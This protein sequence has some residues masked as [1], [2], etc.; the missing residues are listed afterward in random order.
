MKTVFIYFVLMAALFPA[1]A[2]AVTREEAY[3]LARAGDSAAIETAFAQHQ[4][5]FNTGEI[6]P[7]TYQ[8]PYFVFRTTEP[9]VETAIEDWLAAFPNSPQAAAA[10]AERLGHIGG[11]IRGVGYAREVPAAAMI[12]FK[13]IA[14]EALTLATSALDTEPRHL[15]AA[16]SLV[17][18][19]AYLGSRKD[20]D[21]GFRV[22]EELDTPADVL[23]EGLQYNYARWGGGSEDTQLFCE[24]R[25]PLVPDISVAECLAKA[26]YDHVDQ[27]PTLFLP[28][29]A[30]L[31]QGNIEYFVEQHLAALTREGRFEEAYVLA[32]SRNFMNY[33][34]AYA[35]SAALAK[36]DIVVDFVTGKLPSDPLNPTDL[37]IFGDA[38]ADLG[39]LEGA[40]EAMDKAM[41]YGRFDGFVRW[42]RIVLTMRDP[43][44]KW[45]VLD[46]IVRAADDT[47]GDMEIL[48]G[49]L[50]SLIN[51]EEHH[52]MRPD[53]TSRPDFEC[54]RLRLL[55][56]HEQN[57]KAG[58][59][60][61]SCRAGTVAMRDTIII[62][63]RAANACGESTSLTWQDYIRY[64]LDLSEE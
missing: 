38:L 20:R 55:E 32:K 15:V 9:L 46:E 3:K 16:Y 54:T 6:G 45:Q 37:T 7:N 49:V 19:G 52:S 30:T 53:G 35:L 25:A 4:A 62:E 44:R 10:K 27:D 28:A 12:E 13:R 50:F 61:Y 14:L 58:S 48:S 39:D 8:R 59:K 11:L 56:Q 36:T 42:R 18:M 63:A 60:H 41:L 64:L 5:A 2:I 21:R 24:E 57:C 43:E 22:V 1:L 47:D 33:Q 34:L 40:W 17:S 23:L 31:S 26:D 29:V 51:R